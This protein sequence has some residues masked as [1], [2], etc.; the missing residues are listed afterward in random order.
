VWTAFGWAAAVNYALT[1]VIFSI[2]LLLSASPARTGLILLPMTL[3]VAVN[4][5]LTG[6]LAAAY[7]PVVPIRLGF[8]AFPV[9]LCLAAAAVSGDH[10]V[11]LGVGLLLCGLG[12][13][14]TLPALVGYAVEHAG[15][16]AA[17]AV[18]G[19]LNATR[20]IG[21]TVAAATTAAILTPRTPAVP[22]LIAA[23][24]CLLGLASAMARNRTRARQRAPE[25]PAERGSR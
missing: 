12:V 22:F 1:T 15:P 8:V 6:R 19:I 24:V 13:S 10:A 25:A 7:G 5:L 20:Q 17:G 11:L 16:D 21:A 23:A 2:P 14:W 18:G 9:G 3:L 4:P